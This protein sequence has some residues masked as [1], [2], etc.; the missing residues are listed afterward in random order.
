MDLTNLLFLKEY[1]YKLNLFTLDVENNVFRLT[2]FYI[3]FT[4]LILYVNTNEEIVLRLQ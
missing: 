3:Q 1:F 2:N 4:M